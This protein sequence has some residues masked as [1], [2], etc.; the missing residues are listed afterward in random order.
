MQL[1]DLLSVFSPG[2]KQTRRHYPPALKLKQ[3]LI[4]ALSE[5][6]CV[7]A[8]A[9]FGSF[10]KGTFDEYSDVDLIVSVSGDVSTVVD[11]GIFRRTIY[12]RPSGQ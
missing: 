1:V 7:E 3:Q 12:Y 4:T 8:V 5:H 9:L 2:E 6:P 10:A 11:T